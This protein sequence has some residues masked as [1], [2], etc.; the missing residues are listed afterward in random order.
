[1]NHRLVV[2]SSLLCAFVWLG[3]NSAQEVSA[4]DSDD[5]V[6]GSG[7]RVSVSR[8]LPPFTAIDLRDASDLDLHIGTDTSVI[9]EADGNLIER[10]VTE[11]EGDTL[12][13]RSKGG[14][15]M[16]KSPKL[17]VTLPRLTALTIHGSGDADLRGL[18]SESL[19]LSIHGSGDIEAEG[20]AAVL[21]VS[22]H[23]SGDAALAKLVARQVRASIHGSG[24]IDVEARESLDAEVNGSGDIVYGGHPARLSKRVHGSGEIAAR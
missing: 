24:D 22:I 3:I 16:R 17:T 21:G 23:G 20:R 11:V 9:V 19:N 15:S 6:K 2:I 10:I 8:G 14:Y 7:K 4:H 1:M 5:S 18:D 12:I 13:V